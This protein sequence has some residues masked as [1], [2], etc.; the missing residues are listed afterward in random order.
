MADQ[1]LERIEN[2]TQETSSPEHSTESPAEFSDTPK[3]KPWVKIG[4]VAAVILL[5]LGAIGYLA[6]QNYQL[7][8][9]SAPEPISSQ[10]PTQVPAQPTTKPD[11]TANWQTY[12]NEK[13]GF[14]IKY[15]PEAAFDEEGHGLRLEGEEVLGEIN[16]G[17]MGEKQRQGTELYDGYFVNIQVVTDKQSRTSKEIADFYMIRA[18]EGVN[19]IGGVI[20]DCSTKSIAVSG[21][22]GYLF[23][24]CVGLYSKNDKTFIFSRENYV[25]LVSSYVPAEKYLETVEFIL[26]TFKFLDQTQTDETAGWKVYANT[27][28]GYSIK[29][30]KNWKASTIASGANPNAEP[31][32]A[33]QM[34]DIY[35]VNTDKSYPIGYITIQGFGVSADRSAE[36]YQTYDKKSSIDINGIEMIR[37]ELGKIPGGSFVSEV[38][39]ASTPSS[40]SIE[41][42]FRYEPGDPNKVTFD[43]ILSTFEFVD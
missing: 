40:G 10:Q 7:K 8:N 36:S 23:K 22:Q 3:S 39:L 2:S 24:P 41:I 18:R 4:V 37:F 11:P 19:E 29:Y 6:Y 42:L 34:I 30:P 31:H 20:S 26:S 33:A 38:Y 9:Q 13:Y 28:Y 15:P 16:M 32:P 17:F 35:E 27:A 12:V 21:K 5:L 43:Q 1:N 14:E 25:I